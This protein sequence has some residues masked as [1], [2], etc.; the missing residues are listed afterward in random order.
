MFYMQRVSFGLASALLLSNYLIG[1]ISLLA[2]FIVVL[3]L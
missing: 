1:R 3:S 2:H